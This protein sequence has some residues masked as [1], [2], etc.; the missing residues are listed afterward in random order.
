MALATQ[1]PHCG[2]QFRVA[3]DQL[4]LRGG[5]V[6]CGTCQQIFDGNAALVELAPV[7]PAP[8][9]VPA[10]VPVPVPAPSPAPAPA[11]VKAAPPPEPRADTRAEPARPAAPAREYVPL[12]ADFADF[13]PPDDVHDTIAPPADWYAIP[14]TIKSGRAVQ[15]TP[16]PK[17][18]DDVK[19]APVQPVP[20]AAPAPEPE[21]APALARAPE[22]T[23]EP[24]PFAAPAPLP[25]P[26]PVPEP[27]AEVAPEPVPETEPVP[28]PEP[29]APAAPEP[30]PEPEPESEPESEPQPEP[31]PE[32]EPEP[33]P[34][35]PVVPE[36]V[37]EPAPEAL[38]DPAGPRSL[39]LRESAGGSLPIVA[40]ASADAAATGKTPRAR[41][42]EARARRAKPPSAPPVPVPAPAPASVRS[43]VTPKVRAPE[44][45]EP[46]FLRRGRQRERSGKTRRIA[47]A[48]GSTV[49][50]VALALQ[51]AF[52]FRDVL[53]ARHPELRPTL[54]SACALVGCSVGL[55]LRADALAIETGELITL[56][57]GAY[58][59]TTMLR[60][61][62]DM[63]LA[64]PSLELTLNDSDDRPLVRR[65]FAPSDYLGRGFDPANGFGA[66]AE[67]PVKIHFRLEGVN[68]SGYHI[69]VFYP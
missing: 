57:G 54:E 44:A 52:T 11:P 43:D 39:L 16:F 34:P 18:Q 26:E 32:P 3:A 63:T 65:V 62:G 41:A 14:G 27:V 42:A 31:V 4:K 37:P 28:E 48:T 56:G 64:W 8:V 58:T 1:C 6:R 2:T 36:P 7:K 59:F 23:P 5:I 46:E 40:S 53:A 51:S 13:D 69:A 47:L 10:R 55:P 21:P 22:P 68:P 12:P 66:R 19:D 20:V 9:P 25:E 67:Q 60:N 24:E 33:E 15:P 30:A 38:P 61:G 17:L 49:L 45:D 50:L 29:S 35:A